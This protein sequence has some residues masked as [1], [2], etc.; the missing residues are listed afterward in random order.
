MSSHDYRNHKPGLLSATTTEKTM[1]PT[2]HKAPRMQ[3]ISPQKQLHDIQQVL[4]QLPEK[5]TTVVELADQIQSILD[6]EV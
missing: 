1:S 5:A 6:G 3:I 2:K 4:N